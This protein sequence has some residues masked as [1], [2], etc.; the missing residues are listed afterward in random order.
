MSP[1]LC[2]PAADLIAQLS[3]VRRSL[4]VVPLAWHVRIQ[5]DRPRENRMNVLISRQRYRLH[6]CIIF[7]K[8]LRR[9][10]AIRDT[11]YG[12]WAVRK[13]APGVGEKTRVCDELCDA[14]SLMVKPGET[15]DA[16]G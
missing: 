15:R 2:P 14:H 13:G 4:P 5:R 11:E 12:L 7:I 8:R 1:L 16:M 9:M 3:G 6:Q 10:H